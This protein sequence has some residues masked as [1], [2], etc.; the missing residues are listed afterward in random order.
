[1]LSVTAEMVQ[2]MGQLPYEKRLRRLGLFQF[3]G[4]LAEVGYGDYG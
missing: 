3:Q 4:E 1:M 2:R